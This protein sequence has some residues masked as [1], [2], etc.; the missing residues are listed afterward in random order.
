MMSGI[1]HRDTT[2][3]LV[4]RKSLW[5]LGYRYRLHRRDLAG[6]PDIVLPRHR[7]A[8]FVHGCFWHRHAACKLSKLPATRTEFWRAKLQKNVERDRTAQASLLREGWR[9]MTVWECATRDRD[10][11]KRLGSTI[12]NWIA[13]G[14]AVGSISSGGE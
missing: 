4:V 2:P 3:E 6:V 11:A 1:R 5:Q 13:S 8:I 9:V 12:R 14:E 7:V 10:A